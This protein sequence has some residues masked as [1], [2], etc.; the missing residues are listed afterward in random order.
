MPAGDWA[1]MASLVGGRRDRPGV[2][3]ESA[4]VAWRASRPPR[5]PFPARWGAGVCVVEEECAA[6]EVEHDTGDAVANIC[7]TTVTASES[8][9]V[10]AP[11][12]EG[13]HVQRV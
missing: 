11:I 13:S 6:L 4:P 9:L 7:R 2:S 1:P 10:V 3:S 5:A 8:R 12:V